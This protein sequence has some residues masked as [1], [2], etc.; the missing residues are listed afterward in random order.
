MTQ[1]LMLFLFDISWWPNPAGKLSFKNQALFLKFK[2]SHIGYRDQA[3]KINDT[4][5]KRSYFMLQ[6]YKDKK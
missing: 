6:K 3:F 2:C 1:V 4:P 5:Y